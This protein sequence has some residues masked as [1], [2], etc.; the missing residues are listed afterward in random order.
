[1]KKRFFILMVII[2]ITVLFFNCPV[3]KIKDDD[4]NDDGDERTDKLYVIGDIGPSGVGIVFYIIDGGLHGLEVAPGDQS[5]GIIWALAANQ[6][7]TVPAPGATGTVIGTGLVNTNAIIA[8]ND[9]TS[10][11]L[12]TYAAGLARAYNGGGYSDWFLPSKNELNTIWDNLV[13]DGLGNNNGVGGFADNNYWSSSEND[14]NKAWLQFF[15][16]GTQGSDLKYFTLYVRA[17]RA[18]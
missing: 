15:N 3:D 18:F 9:P 10:L 17:V 11:G 8:Q 5:T 7:T 2:L 16:H 1:M 14:A 4:D 12:I 13:D 6:S